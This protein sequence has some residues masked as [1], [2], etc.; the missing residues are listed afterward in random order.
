MNE[1]YNC[2]VNLALADAGLVKTAAG[3]FSALGGAARGAR[4]WLAA[5]PKTTAALVGVPAMGATM[6]GY[7]KLVQMARDEARSRA[8]RRTLLGAGIGGLG[9]SLAAAAAGDKEGMGI[10][11]LKGLAAG[12]ALGALGGAAAPSLQRAYERGGV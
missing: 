3:V 4:K 12:G 10:R 5:H 8:L 1:F 2:G 6:L 9:G 11:A 7:H